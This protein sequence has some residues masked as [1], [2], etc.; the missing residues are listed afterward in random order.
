[1]SVGAVAR[2]DSTEAHNRNTTGRGDKIVLARNDSETG[3]GNFFI[4][5]AYRGGMTSFINHHCDSNMVNVKLTKSDNHRI[6]IVLIF[7]PAEGDLYLDNRS[8]WFRARFFVF[9]TF[10]RVSIVG[11]I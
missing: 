10:F 1:M 6:F 9:I 2:I 11:Q 3:H 4:N 8:P 5:G 7:I